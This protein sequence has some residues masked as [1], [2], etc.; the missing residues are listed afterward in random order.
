M[1]SLLLL[2]ALAVASPESEPM[3][4]MHTEC[5]ERGLV[6]YDLHVRMTEDGLTLANIIEG[7]SA[8]DQARITYVFGQP[9]PIEAYR[10]M[11]QICEMDKTKHGQRIEI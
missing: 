10:L 9:D 8:K 2:A 3:T 5:Q 7:Q 4:S 11:R 6:A 1:N